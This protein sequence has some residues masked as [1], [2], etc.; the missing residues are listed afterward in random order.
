M[1]TFLAVALCL[2]TLAAV[3]GDPTAPGGNTWPKTVDEAASQLR[4]R[5]S[6]EDLEWIRRNPK[7]VVTSQLHLPYGTGV[8]NEFGLWGK[9]RPL[10]KSC[11]VEDAEECSGI[12]FSA[13]W[14]KVRSET[15]PAISKSLDCHFS[16]LDRIEIDTTGWYQLQLGQLLSDLQQQIDRQSA[17]IS[18]CDEA[19]SIVVLGDPDV[20]CFVRV[21]YE[22]KDSLGRLFQWV[23]FRNAFSVAHNPPNIQLTFNQRCAWPERPKLFTPE[24]RQ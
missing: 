4:S 3:A 11:G 5:L 14:D 6:P 20:Q 15:D 17:T 12:I 9:N 10:L 19:I 22:E 21:E 7:D 24:G 13:L 2:A 16:A 23:G 8:R 1:K 18:G